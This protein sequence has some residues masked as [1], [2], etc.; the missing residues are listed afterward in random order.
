[1]ELFR[2]LDTIAIENEAANRAQEKLTGA[3]AEL[4]RIGEPILTAIKDKVADMVTAAVPHLENFVNKVKAAAAW[5]KD[6]RNTIDTWVAVIIGAGTA[7]GT[8]L[9]ILNWAPS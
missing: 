3:F 6:N 2:L 7:I 1:M 4:G 8:F 5:V 9:L